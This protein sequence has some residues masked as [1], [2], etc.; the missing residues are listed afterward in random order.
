MRNKIGALCIGLGLL[1]ILGALALFGWNQLE[2]MRAGAEAES[3][4]PRL[5][6]YIEAQDAAPATNLPP[7]LQ[8]ESEETAEI[9]GYSYIGFLSIPALD[10]ELPVMS[11]WDYAKL[12]ISPCR[13]VGSAKTDD[14][15]IAAHNYSRHFG[16]LSKLTSG[17]EV[18]FIDME[19]VRYTYTVEVIETLEP[20]AIEEM[21]DSDYALTLFTCT[22]GGQMRVTVRCSRQIRKIN[23]GQGLDEGIQSRN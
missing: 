7:E 19:G 16:N 23:E 15:V 21:T 1:F 17:D 14:L 2:D 12:K 9:D 3:Y 22:Y 20:D 10:L 11:E 6:E 13:Y 8:K 4:L 18:Y 5:V